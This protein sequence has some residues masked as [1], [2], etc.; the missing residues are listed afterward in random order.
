MS[1]VARRRVFRRPGLSVSAA[2]TYLEQLAGEDACAYELGAL[3]LHQRM[4]AFQESQIRLPYT[5]QKELAFLVVCNIILDNHGCKQPSLLRGVAQRFMNSAL[6]EEFQDVL[7]ERCSVCFAKDV[8]LDDIFWGEKCICAACERVLCDAFA[9]APRLDAAGFEFCQFPLGELHKAF[10][11][12]WV[13]NHHKAYYHVACFADAAG[14]VAAMRT[15]ELTA[16]AASLVED[17]SS[18]GLDNDLDEVDEADADHVSSPAGNGE[19]DDGIDQ[20]VSLEQDAALD[21]VPSLGVES[22]RQLL[23]AD[24]SALGQSLR[25]ADLIAA[26]NA[27]ALETANDLAARVQRAVGDDR[28]LVAVAADGFRRASAADVLGDVISAAVAVVQSKP[29]RL[30]DID[31]GSLMETVKKAKRCYGEACDALVT[32][33]ERLA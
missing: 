32:V 16:P 9:K 19:T 4:R 20:P 25:M 17:Y 24:A 11:M 12:L 27:V 33:L 21:R 30:R 5:S 29:D 10:Q 6:V 22:L 28:A 8:A 18:S 3:E 2:L 31:V 1:H 7:S 14:T 23:G 15:G 13:L 26:R